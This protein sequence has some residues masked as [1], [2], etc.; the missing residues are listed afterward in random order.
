[1]ALAAPATESLPVG[2]ISLHC[3]LDLSHTPGITE[4]SLTCE[5]HQGILIVVCLKEVPTQ[6]CGMFL[7]WNPVQFSWSVCETLL[8]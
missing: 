1:M 6:Q 4:K 3:G 7:A 2:P 8:L 5:A